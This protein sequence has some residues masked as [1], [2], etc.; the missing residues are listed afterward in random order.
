MLEE[1]RTELNEYSTAYCQ[2]TDTSGAYDNSDI[3]RKINR[4]QKFLFNM[5]FLRFPDLFLASSDV[6][7]SSGVYT[8]PSDLYRL[9][10]IVNSNGDK[11]YPINI[12]SK[13][14]ANNTGSDNLYYRSANTIVR[15]SGISDALTFHYYKTVRD[16]TQG[17]SS[18]GGLK[19]LTLATTAKP[20]ADYYNSVSL[21]DVSDGW[22]DTISDYSAGRVATITTSTGAASKYYG[23]IS[24][25]PDVFHGLISKR[26][27]LDLQGKLISAR[28]PSASDVSG[29][30]EELIETLRAFTGSNHGDGSFS[31]LFYDFE[32][33]M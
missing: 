29:F 30:Q 2:G 17:M 25:L 32:P 7:G 14:L 20:I 11:I 21:E 28:H 19:S 6:T 26:A 4:S 31:E 9:S 12:K 23:T 22:V 5:L 1:I 10:H 16:L 27:T 24:E 18:A 13:H 15:D 8:I 33:Y 3:V